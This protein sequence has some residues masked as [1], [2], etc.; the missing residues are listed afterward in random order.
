MIST[1]QIVYIALFSW[2][3]SVIVKMVRSRTITAVFRLISSRTRPYIAESDKLLG[4]SYGMTEDDCFLGARFRD[5]S[6]IAPKPGVMV[7]N[8]FR[9]FLTAEGTYKQTLSW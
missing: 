5:K 1:V 4:A 9:F 3:E 7:L 8:D 6:I 2:Q